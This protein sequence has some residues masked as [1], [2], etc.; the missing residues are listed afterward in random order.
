MIS[1]EI[2]WKSFV[3]IVGNIDTATTGD[4]CDGIVS[5][6]VTA[7]G[8]KSDSQVEKGNFRFPLPCS[9]NLINC[10]KYNKTLQLIV[11]HASSDL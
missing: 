2:E 7:G 4:A 6:S 9:A 5:H 10:T 3:V 1:N 11:L 8:S